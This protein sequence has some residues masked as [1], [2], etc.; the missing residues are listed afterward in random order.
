MISVSNL[1]F[2]N[3]GSF[4]APT[5]VKT[6][7]DGGT[8]DFFVAQMKWGLELLR[9]R[10]HLA[11]HMTRLETDGQYFNMI[12]TGD[13]EEYI[14]LDFTVVPPTIPLP[15]NTLLPLVLAL[16]DVFFRV[17]GTSLPRCVFQRLPRSCG[18]CA[19]LEKFFERG[20]PE[21]GPKMGMGHGKRDQNWDRHATTD[22]ILTF[23]LLGHRKGTDTGPWKS[24]GTK[25]GPQLIRTKERA[26]S[27]I[28]YIPYAANTS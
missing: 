26:L 3:L 12:E 21:N 6:G 23:R 7:T 8:I 16:T 25:T 5:L 10:D 22:C 19:M 28:V 1:S 17:S 20:Y 9:G 13:V 27:Q 2:S 4:A 24:E 11:E 14:V 15:G 18:G